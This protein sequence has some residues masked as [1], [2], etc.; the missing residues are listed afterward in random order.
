MWRNTAGTEARAGYNFFAGDQETA[1]AFNVSVCRI[2]QASY[3][4][5]EE[6]LAFANNNPGQGVWRL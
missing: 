2:G 3:A 1:Q 6:A 5:L 4:S